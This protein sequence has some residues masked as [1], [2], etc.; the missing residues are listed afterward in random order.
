MAKRAEV[1][2]VSGMK[3]RATKAWY[4]ASARRVMLEFRNGHLFGIPI[5]YLPEV[6]N[7]SAAELA[8]VEVAGAGNI[9]HW[10]SLDA[11]YSVLALA[12]RGIGMPPVAS[13]LGR[14]GGRATSRAKAAAARANGRKG[15]RP[16]KAASTKVRS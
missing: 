12:M 14:R 5:E 2:E 6:K 15:G 9:L 11:D 10:E 16:R 3:Q 8:T 4:D 7:A 13:E 1:F